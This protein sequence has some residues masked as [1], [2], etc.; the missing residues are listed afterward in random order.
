MDKPIEWNPDKNRTLKALRGISFEQVVRAIKAKRI[1]FDGPHP[2]Q[3]KY[4]HQQMLIVSIRSYAYLVPY[5]ED[6]EKRFLKTII[7]SRKANKTY[8]NK[9]GKNGK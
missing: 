9:G 4:P 1:L 2:N 6:S 5:V 7:P 3:S 8:N